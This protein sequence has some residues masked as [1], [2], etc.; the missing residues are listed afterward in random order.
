MTPHCDGGGA[1][2]WQA[3]GHS[4]SSRCEHML[5]RQP[6]CSCRYLL[7]TA[8]TLRLKCSAMACQ[9]SSSLPSSSL[10]VG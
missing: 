3:A 7:R 4:D 9:S 1:Y 5:V 8:C 2:S 10:Q 6:T